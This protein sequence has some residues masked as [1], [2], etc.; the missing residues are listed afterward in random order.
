MIMARLSPQHKKIQ[1]LML[2]PMVVLVQAAVAWGSAAQEPRILQQEEGACQWT[3]V[4]Q[5]ID[6][7]REGDRF[8]WSIALTGDG[9]RVAVGAS[10]HGECHQ[11]SM[12]N[13]DEIVATNDSGFVAWFV[14]THLLSR[15]STHRR[16]FFASIW[17]GQGL[18]LQCHQ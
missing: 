16:A 5:D 6:A 2:W 11:Q 8:G 12:A 7:E 13:Y 3:Q 4:G 9:S 15:F 17:A 14:L 18:G 10:D 1:L